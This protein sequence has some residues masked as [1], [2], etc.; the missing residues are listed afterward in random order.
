MVWRAEKGLFFIFLTAAL[1][2]WI[3]GE[4]VAIPKILKGN[5][6]TDLDSLYPLKWAIWTAWG[7]PI[8]W[9]W[10]WRLGGRESILVTDEI[11]VLKRGLFGWG[12]NRVILIKDIEY[13]DIASPSRLSRWLGLGGHLR[14]GFANE[15]IKFGVTLDAQEAD[16]FHELL[17]ERLGLPV[18]L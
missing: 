14:L 11:L 13:L 3:R 9:S 17:S 15:K 5:N 2:F 18:D 12:R 4:Y 16:Q 10:L 7:I 1:L 6:L 8:V